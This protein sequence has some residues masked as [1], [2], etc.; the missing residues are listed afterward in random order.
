M[1]EVTCHLKCKAHRVVLPHSFY[2]AILIILQ[3]EDSRVIYLLILLE[4]VKNPRAAVRA[5]GMA[6]P[7]FL[8]ADKETSAACIERQ[9]PRLSYSLEA[10]PLWKAGTDL[11]PVF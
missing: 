5:Q 1:H 8:L 7:G 6:N 4:P 11:V 3:E 10:H 9:E 2:H